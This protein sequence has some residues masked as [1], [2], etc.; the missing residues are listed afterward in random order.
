MKVGEV[1]AMRLGKCYNWGRDLA[2]YEVRFQ[3]SLT[4]SS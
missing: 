4:N 3:I 1:S 2:A